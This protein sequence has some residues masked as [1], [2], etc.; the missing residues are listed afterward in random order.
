VEKEII[1]SIYLQRLSIAV[2]VLVL[3]PMVLA[4][5]APAQG[6]P[7][8]SLIIFT[9]PEDP[10]SFNAIVGDTGYDALVSNMVMLG[11]TG[12]DPDG[13]IYPELAAEL[14]SRE[15]GGVSV[16][17]NAGTMDVTWKLRQD[18]KWSDGTPVTADDVVFTWNAIMDPEKGI[19][20]R[21]SDYV[22]SV[23]KIDEHTVVFHYNTLYTGYLTQ[24]GGE[25]LVVWPAHYCDAAQ[26]FSQWDCGRQPLSNG[27]F[28]LKEWQVGDH[29][30]FEKNPD[31]YEAGKP[32][33]EKIIIKIVPDDSVRKE[34]LLK[35]DSDLVMWVSETIAKELEGQPNIAVSFSPSNR[36]VLRVHMN[37]AARGTTD[38]VGSPNPFFADVRVRQA[39]RQAID[40]D[41]ITKTVFYGYSSPAWTEFNRE[42][43]KCEV[44]RPKYDPEAAK[45]LLEEAGW[46]DT[47]GDGVRECRG[48]ANANE[49]DLLEFELA[50]YPDYGEPFL[51]T[52]Q[53]I[54][55]QLTKVGMKP[56]LVVIE[57]N[58]MW[59]EAEAGG[60]EQRGDY[61][62]DL[63]DDGY[64]GVDPTDFLDEIYNSSAAVPGSGWNIT[65]WISPEMDQLLTESHTLD[66]DKRKEVFCQMAQLLD[67]Q[68]PVALLFTIINADAHSAR[69]QGIQSNGNDLVTWNVADWTVK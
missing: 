43:Y 39:V 64:S 12:I 28:V 65:R 27:P 66:E 50:T 60:T 61:D 29:M 14:P 13:K 41:T 40:V 69:L 68:V 30:T 67:E 3:L 42:P 7:V 5:C 25:Q 32:G 59:A 9:I 33:I 19:W 63:W 17:E 4:G 53:L 10:P 46:K 62:M 54:G 8:Q 36:W 24:L 38:P 55:E 48:C 52:Q 23:E 35:G 16:D 22:D 37:E 45:T 20:V 18:V 31:Y 1:M 49:G 51:L 44:P 2:G 58:V 56:N 11:L 21:G 57:G 6:S 47:D 26:G 15:N 34:M